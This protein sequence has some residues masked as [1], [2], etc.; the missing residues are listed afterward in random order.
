VFQSKQAQAAPLPPS[1]YSSDAFFADEQLRVFRNSWNVVCAASALPHHGD[2]LAM[3]IGGLPVL[4]RN[5]GGTLRAYRNVCPHRHS[6]VAPAGR[7]CTAQLRCQYHGW[8][9]AEDGRLARL[10]DGPS[11]R[12]WKATDAQLLQLRC[13]VAFGLVLVNPA[14]GAAPL[15]EELGPIAAE[16]RRHFDG[17][18]LYY[19]QVSEHE[20]NWKVIVDNAIESYHV[21]MLHPATF[22]NYHDEQF[23]GHVVEPT[24]TQYHDLKS[25][26]RAPPRDFALDQLLFRSHRLWGY[27]H[28]HVFPNHCITYA[29]FY[30]EWMIAEPLGPRRTRRTAYGFFPDDVEHA[31]LLGRAER[32]MVAEIAR[33]TRKG[34]DRIL[35]E[36]S[37][38]WGSVQTGTEHSPYPGVLSAREERVTAFHRWL[39]G[40]TG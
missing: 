14:P 33:R 2:Q 31:G 25:S 9:F 13:E 7:S 1:A 40:R 35:A 19:T 26:D 21:P 10:P 3:P 17:T 15:E 5:D 32:L 20:V 38:V 11:F 16:L 29:G 27:S 36:D 37:R 28:T 12:G 30:R 8:E 24:F 18:R 22:G 6:M 39:L 4:V 34:A 23:H